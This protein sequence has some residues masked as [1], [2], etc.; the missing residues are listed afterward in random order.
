M[1]HSVNITKKYNLNKHYQE[2]MINKTDY[3][4]LKFVKFEMTT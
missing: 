4:N 2:Q 1:D 3:S